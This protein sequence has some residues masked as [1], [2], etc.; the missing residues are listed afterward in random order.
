MGDDRA[1]AAV[2]EGMKLLP[3]KPAAYCMPWHA[4]HFDDIPVHGARCCYCER[5]IAAPESV[6]G[7]H[8]ACIYCG[9]DRGEL[10]SQEIEPS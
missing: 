1:Y 5:E 8:V 6:R 3:P 7:Q 9:L 2:C 10:A 4:R